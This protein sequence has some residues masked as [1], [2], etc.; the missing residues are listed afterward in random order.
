ML[1][2]R[3]L[4]AAPDVPVSEVG[5]RDGTRARVG[6]AIPVFVESPGW[7]VHIHAVVGLYNRS[8]MNLFPF[9]FWRGLLGFRATH[10]WP[11]TIAGTRSAAIGIDFGFDHESDHESFAGPPVFDTFLYTNALTA[12]GDFLVDFGE[13][14]LNVGLTARAHLFSCTDVNAPCD[15]VTGPNQQ[16]F[17]ANLDV[18]L[19]TGNA[20]TA[21][22][23]IR[24]CSALHLGAITGL[25]DM[26][27]ELRAA[28]L[29]GGCIRFSET[30]EWQ[31]LANGVLGNDTGMHRGIRHAQLG[32]VAR[33][34]L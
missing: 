17:E 10:R 6:L 32:A 28:L 16:G 21:D 8:F 13:L 20:N 12:R 15:T 24:F 19:R 31:L 25:S 2:L 29:V 3:H 33:W 23:N 14:T 26:T 11:L 18:A 30:G 5:W 34:V 1:H 4:S 22:G 9:E 27:E 7:S